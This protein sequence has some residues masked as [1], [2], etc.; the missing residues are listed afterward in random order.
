MSHSIDG[1]PPHPHEEEG[2]PNLGADELAV[3]AEAAADAATEMQEPVAADQHTAAPVAAVMTDSLPVYSELNG[4]NGDQQQDPT[5]PTGIDGTEGPVNESDTYLQPP[6]ENGQYEGQYTSTDVP[7]PPMMDWNNNSHEQ[8][9]AAGPANSQMNSSMELHSPIH[10][11]A[12]APTTHM[13]LPNQEHHHEDSLAASNEPVYTS[14]A[15]PPGTHQSHHQPTVHYHHPGPH[16]APMP[17]HP[18]YDPNAQH[19]PYAQ[20]PHMSPYGGPQPP[21]MVPPPYASAPPPRVTTSHNNPH[22]NSNFWLQ[23]EEERFLLGLRLYGWGQW[24]RIQTVVQTRSNKQIKSH[25][26]KREK[27]NPEIKV[28]YAKGKSRRGRISA[29]K[30]GDELSNPYAATAGVKEDNIALDDPNLPPMEELWKDV[31]GTNNGVGPNS[32]L[33]RYRSNALHQKWLEEV[34]DKPES[35]RSGVATEKTL[36]EPGHAKDTSKKKLTP[37]G[38][39]LQE[40]RVLERNTANQPPQSSPGPHISYYNQPHPH[41]YGTHPGYGMPP[42]GASPTRMQ[43]YPHHQGYHHP[44]MPTIGHQATPSHHRGPPVRQPPVVHQPHVTADGENTAETPSTPSGSNEE[45]LRPGMRVYARN[46]NSTNWSSGVIYSAKVD[47]NNPIDTNQAAIPLVY[48]V[49][50]DEGEED[51]EVQEECILGKLTYEKALEELEAHYDLLLGRGKSNTPL[52]PGVPVY[53]QWM[54]RSNPTSHGRW[55]PGTVGSVQNNESPNG[56]I[57]T[58]HILFDNASEKVDV[59][60]DCVLDRNEYHELVKHKHHY[61]QLDQ[62]RTPIGEIYNL[63]SR[64]GDAN[65]GVTGQGMDLLFTASQMAAPMDTLKKRGEPEVNGV[66]GTEVEPEAKKVKLEEGGEEEDEQRQNEQQEGA[67]SLV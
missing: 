41:H 25:A 16:A 33:R 15:I 27:V 49:H 3:A 57:K 7:V 5:A 26:Q 14:Y 47:P 19:H 50:Y 4:G 30:V 1:F 56:P 44:P 6:P 20:W 42:P 35:E 40:H 38:Q 10:A 32:R 29:S 24:K 59:P 51:F 54:D 58:Y 37:E 60:S 23:E 61:Q 28:K 65:I 17:P 46:K 55:L 13:P 63:F 34:A 43:S 67:F 11:P 66:N 22:H 52:D 39:Y 21:G 53:A 36:K 31:Y 18:H 45:S 48:H 64:G 12:E 2:V 8:N 62:L 9:A